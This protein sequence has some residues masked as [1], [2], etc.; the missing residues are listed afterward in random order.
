MGKPRV[1]AWL[2]EV[3][4]VNSRAAT[5]LHRIDYLESER[6]ESPVG[7]YRPMDPQRDEIRR[8]LEVA[9]EATYR[10]SKEAMADQEGENRG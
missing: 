8:A 3:R 1:S 7:W 5:A 6:A 9:Y 4:T 10:F 2:T